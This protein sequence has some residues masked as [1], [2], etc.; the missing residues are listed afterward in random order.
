MFS[1]AV[2]FKSSG[3]SLY[4]SE[5]SV[6]EKGTSRFQFMVWYYLRDT[7]TFNLP[8][9]KG[10]YSHIDAL[11]LLILFCGKSG[12]FETVNIDMIEKM[13]WCNSEDY[14]CGCFSVVVF[15]LP[16]GNTIKVA[17]PFVGGGYQV[18]FREENEKKVLPYHLNLSFSFLFI[19]GQK[20]SSRLYWLK[21]KSQNHYTNEPYK[22]LFLE[23]K[24]DVFDFILSKM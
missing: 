24:E 9:K 23:T 5:I 6:P 3:R 21:E 17:Y 1:F 16:N 11:T 4:R 18:F 12:L 19:V 20:D 7:N 2:L 8:S 10:Y 13:V 22:E 15:T 14:S